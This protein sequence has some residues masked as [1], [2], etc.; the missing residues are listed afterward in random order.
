[1]LHKAKQMIGRSGRFLLPG[2]MV[3]LAVMCLAVFP[4][5]ATHEELS[6]EDITLAVETNLLLDDAVSSYLVDVETN[7]GIVTLS[8]EVDNLLQKIRAE[9]LTLATRGVRSVVNQIE[10]RNVAR[11]DDQVHR[12]VVAALAVDPA[13]DSY[14]IDVAVERGVVTLA[15]EV[16]SWRE[17]SLSETVATGVRGVQDV[18]NEITIG[19]VAER[20]DLEIKAEIERYYETDVYLNEDF[21]NV[22]VNNGRVTLDGR[23]GSAAEKW[24]AYNNAWVNGVNSVTME[25]VEIVS[26]LSEDKRTPAE[27]AV[28]SDEEVEQAVEDALLWDP[29]V[30]SAE[31][32]VRVNDGAVTLSGMQDNLR[33]KQAATRTAMNTVGV[34]N[35]TN[36]IR[37][38]PEDRP[39][40]TILEERVTSALFRDPYVEDVKV[41]VDVWHGIV[42]LTGAVSSRFEKQHAGEIAAGVNGVVAVDNDM[43]VEEMWKWRD[44][45]V[46]RNDIESQLYWSPFVD[47]DEVDVTVN[48]GVA[49]LTGTVD[50]WFER[51]MAA[52]NAREGGARRV[53]NRLMVDNYPETWFE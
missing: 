30:N 40:D 32:G 10:V 33:A 21:L 26:W 34:W 52:E 53:L 3:A 6:D 28:M 37:V 17:R 46:I 8:G 14:E 19:D 13:T 11:S 15:G 9:K 42:T 22:A 50:T 1:M 16:D 45:L 5:A 48:D 35:V 23:V 4:A 29:R 27:G 2:A 43:R 25:D 18:V 12:D 39:S 38:R 20:T 47:E 7:M 24:R 44:D 41:D 36:L 49:T 51:R 31:I